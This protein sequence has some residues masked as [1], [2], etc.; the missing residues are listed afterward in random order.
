MRGGGGGGEEEEE[1]VKKV[2][3]RK[4]S[5]KKQM[6]PFTYFVLS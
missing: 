1:E 4:F 3:G 5:L 2:R 6:P